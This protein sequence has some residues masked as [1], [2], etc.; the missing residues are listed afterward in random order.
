MLL[1]CVTLQ[2]NSNEWFSDL[3]VEVVCGA[4]T[5]ETCPDCPQGNGADWCNGDCVWLNG[6]CVDRGM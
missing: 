2:D 1:D 4:H 5:A 3:V 6:G